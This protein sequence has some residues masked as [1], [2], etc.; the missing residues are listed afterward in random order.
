MNKL[1][2]ALSV[3]ALGVVAVAA[4]PV[5]VHAG[6]AANQVVQHFTIGGLKF[7]TGIVRSARYSADT[8]QHIGYTTYKSTN[9]VM[10]GTC[11]GADSNSLYN[12]CYTTDPQ[13][14]AVMQSVGP[15]SYV[16]FDYD[17]NGA[18]TN[19]TVNNTSFGM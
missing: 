4:A 3:G 7:T 14:I 19:V 12:S 1:R 18:C 11:V 2:V 10:G 15:I 9:G 16:T 8:K 17:A 5:A 13:M 6:Y